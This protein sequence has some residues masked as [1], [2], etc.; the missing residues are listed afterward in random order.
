MFLSRQLLAVVGKD[1]NDQ[2]Y[3]IAWAIVEVKNIDSWVWF[4]IELQ[5]CLALHEGNGVTVI[6]DEHQVICNHNLYINFLDM[7][8]ND[9]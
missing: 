6:S 3:P 1:G 5:K 4:F 2:M 9:N 7:V 8:Y